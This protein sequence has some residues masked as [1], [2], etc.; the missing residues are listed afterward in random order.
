ME[1]PPFPRLTRVRTPVFLLVAGIAALTGACADQ[2]PAAPAASSPAA[3]TA[4]VRGAVHFTGTP[5]P[6]SVIRLDGDRTCTE[7]NK[8]PERTV[9]TVLT[10]AG[11]TV[12]DVFVYV[13]DGLNGRTYPAPTDPVVID[14]QRCEYV[15][16][17]LGIQVGQPLAIRN[18]DPLLHNIR[19]DAQVNQPFNLGEPVPMTMTKVFATREVMVPVKCD[20]HAW[21]RAHIGVLDHPFFAVTGNDGAFALQNLPAG[22]YTLE[23]WH[24]TLGTTTAQVT[25]G[26]GESK[27]VN[28]TFAITN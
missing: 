12:Q 4:A 6:P 25:L 11:N 1:G 8:G 19:A 5:P 14:Q 21:M 23:A 17:V 16:R 26:D 13:K 15:P 7:L 27:D 18:S 2:P 24:E 3:D 9:H 20:V 28:F 10:G 22:T